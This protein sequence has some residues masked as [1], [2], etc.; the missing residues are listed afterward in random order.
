MLD[1][2]EPTGAAETRL[3]LVDDEKDAVLLGELAQ[4]LQELSR[5]RHESALAEHRLDDDR[6]HALGGHI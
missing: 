2:E 3:D 1:G 4:P 5:R 6:G